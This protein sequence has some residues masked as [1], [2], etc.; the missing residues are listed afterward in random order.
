[1]S[2]TQGSTFG[3]FVAIDSA[4]VDGPQPRAQRRANKIKPG[5]VFSGRA[6]ARFF[7]S[8]ERSLS[9][10]KRTLVRKGAPKPQERQR[11]TTRAYRPV[12]RTGASSSTSS[13][14]PG[15]PE[16]ASPLDLPPLDQCSCGSWKFEDWSRCAFC[17]WEASRTTGPA[18]LT[19][20]Y[21]ESRS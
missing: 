3:R 14:D 7:A 9:A 11:G 2:S 1:M 10:V 13:A 20:P 18:Q 16:P 8:I 19:L 5:T 12:Q 6:V 21:A 15:D 17:E 4:F